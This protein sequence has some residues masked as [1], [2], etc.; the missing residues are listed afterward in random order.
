MAKYSEEERLVLRLFETWF[1]PDNDQ[2]ESRKLAIKL[3][4][5]LKE[6]GGIRFRFAGTQALMDGALNEFIQDVEAVGG[7]IQDDEG[8]NFADENAANWSDLAQTY[9]IACAA[10]KRKPM[11]RRE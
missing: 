4:N 3:L 6:T 8:T 1:R 9:L 7:I 2:R 10:L 11:V 5:Q